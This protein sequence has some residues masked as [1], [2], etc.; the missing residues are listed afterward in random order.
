MDKE[1][2][3]LLVRVFAIAQAQEDVLNYRSGHP[4]AH[5]RG[6]A[7]AEKVAQELAAV[8]D[9]R[10]TGIKGPLGALARQAYCYE[11]ERLYLVLDRRGEE[12]QEQKEPA[13]K[14]HQRDYC[15]FCQTETEQEVDGTIQRCLTCN[16]FNWAD[17]SI[18][19][20]IGRLDAV[21]LEARSRYYMLRRA[22]Y[23]QVQTGGDGTREGS[24]GQPPFYG[25]LPGDK[26]PGRRQS[27][28]QGRSQSL[29]KRAQSDNGPGGKQKDG[30]QEE[31]C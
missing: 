29:G 31:T 25:F 6:E 13:S 15:Q 7:L 10:P 11:W 30:D 14:P 16:G 22:Y 5:L 26:W 24:R 17:D 12:V 19:S 21:L 2:E 8:E 27:G 9:G 23:Q 20:T 3:D 4:G 28:R 18:P 1:F